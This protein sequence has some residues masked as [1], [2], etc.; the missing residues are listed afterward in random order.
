VTDGAGGDWPAF[1]EGTL[2]PPLDETGDV[3]RPEE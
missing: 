2:H 3:V 1:L